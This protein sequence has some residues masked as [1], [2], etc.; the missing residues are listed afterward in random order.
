MVAAF[1]LAMIAGHWSMAEYL[2]PFFWLDYK[3][4]GVVGILL[5]FGGYALLTPAAARTIGFIGVAIM[6]PVIRVRRQLLTDQVGRASWRSGV[7]CCGLMVGLSLIV[8]TVVHTES[9]VAGWDFPKDLAEAFVW[10][11]VPVPP[12]T[13]E[14]IK[15]VPGVKEFTLV[16]DIECDLEGNR[17]EWQEWVKPVF[18]AGDLESFLHIVNI[19]FVEGNR[20]DAIAR[21]QRGSAVL[22]TPE[23]AS[24]RNTGLGDNITVSV[25]GRSHTFEVAG[26][27]ES[28]A[29]DIA[30]TFFNAT[31]HLTLASVGAVLGTFEDAK[32]YFG[33]EGYTLVLLNFDLPDTPPP[34]NW[35]GSK[36]RDRQTIGQFRLIDPKQMTNDE[37]WRWSREVAVLNQV[38]TAIGRRSVVQ[39]SI[40]ELKRA[41]DRD[42]RLATALFASIP[43]VAMLVAA[44]GVANLMMAN[45]TSRSR[46]IA[47]L[48]AIGGDQMADHPLG[49][50]GGPDPGGDRN[51]G[52]AGAGVSR[53]PYG[54][55]DGVQDVRV[56][57]A[58]DCSL[59]AYRIGGGVYDAGLLV[60]GD[61][62]GPSCGTE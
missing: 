25:A 36:L 2:P 13:A 38:R 27:V 43:V 42:L 31:G 15:R 44:L 39:G 45:V 10:T 11:T 9:I 32:R 7:I 57:D 54:E 58:V 48:R 35:D 17:S 41:I 37:L 60:G 33:V 47:V 1:G 34:D 16:N 5:I 28:P 55:P 22:I 26:I 30:A 40:R 20:E 50:R 14:K 62:A 61:I 8:C 19:G 12:A 6:A 3:I 53:G 49:G 23:Y 18:A 21:L 52:R 59:A 24:S 56:H 29:L 4:V 46:Q 51:G